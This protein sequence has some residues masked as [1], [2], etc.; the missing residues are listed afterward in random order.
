VLFH[1]PQFA[2]C[3]LDEWKRPTE[4]HADVIL[5]ELTVA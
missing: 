2:R 4:L 3:C 5:V 1:L